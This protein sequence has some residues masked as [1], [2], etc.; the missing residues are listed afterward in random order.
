MSE[1]ARPV[2]KPSRAERPLTCSACT[3]RSKSSRKEPMVSA[4]CVKGSESSVS[5][6]E[7]RPNAGPS[8]PRSAAL[9]ARVRTLLWC[10]AVTLATSAE[11]WAENV[12]SAAT[13]GSSGSLGWGE[14]EGEG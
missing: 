11:Y 8:C 3:R 5:V 4:I 14:G 13:A 7:S 2:L 9:S 6:C 1:V 12:R 10:A